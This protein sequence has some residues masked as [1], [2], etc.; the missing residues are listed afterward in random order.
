LRY[1]NNALGSFL[2]GYQSNLNKKTL[3]KM[4]Y[5]HRKLHVQRKFK[6]AGWLDA[7]VLKLIYCFIL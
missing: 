5:V 7:M 1:I 6:A 2:K 3:T 4:R